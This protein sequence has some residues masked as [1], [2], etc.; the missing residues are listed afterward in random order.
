[1]RPGSAPVNWV[2]SI[3]RTVAVDQAGLGPEYGIAPA[4]PRE[5]QVQ[6]FHDDLPFAVHV[7]VRHQVAA[8]TAHFEDDRSMIGVADL[9]G[10]DAGPAGVVRVS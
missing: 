10:Y 1:M 7:L 9:V 6:L 5:V 3:D 8:R 2:R 4:D